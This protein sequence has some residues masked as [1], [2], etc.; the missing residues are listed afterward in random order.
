M[1]ERGF[2]RSYVDGAGEKERTVNLGESRRM[3]ERNRDIIRKATCSLDQI[4]HTE[5]SL[6]VVGAG[7]Q[8]KGKKNIIREDESPVCL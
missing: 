8:M 6:Q 1:S 4:I 2:R 3:G 5:R 7:P